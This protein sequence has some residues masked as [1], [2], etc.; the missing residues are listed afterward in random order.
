MKR[1]K[2][3]SLKNFN[4]ERGKKQK[5]NKHI[6]ETHATHKQNEQNTHHSTAPGSKNVAGK[7]QGTGGGI[8]DNGMAGK[9]QI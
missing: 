9:V 1:Q 8:G 6:G 2:D 7:A 3:H 4:L 5:A